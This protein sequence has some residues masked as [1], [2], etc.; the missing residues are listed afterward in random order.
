M[1]I[2]HFVYSVMKAV[3]FCEALNEYCFVD[4]RWECFTKFAKIISNLNNCL[5]HSISVFV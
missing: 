2:P 1:N 3:Y 4:L 5:C